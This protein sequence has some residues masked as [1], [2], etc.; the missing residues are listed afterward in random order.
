MHF[1]VRLVNMKTKQQGGLFTLAGSIF[2]LNPML[3][4]EKEG[5]NSLMCDL[6]DGGDTK[7]SLFFPSRLYFTGENVVLKEEQRSRMNPHRLVQPLASAISVKC[8][9]GGILLHCEG[10]FLFSGMGTKDKRLDW[11]FFHVIYQ[12]KLEVLSLCRGTTGC[13]SK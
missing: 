6:R 1:R 2:I 12:E 11:Y 3:T 9:D 7:L 5:L 8:V 4:W 10:L 13:D